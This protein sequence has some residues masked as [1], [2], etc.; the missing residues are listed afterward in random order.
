MLALVILIQNYPAYEC[1]VV[2]GMCH[3]LYTYLSSNKH[4][5]SMSVLC[6]VFVFIDVG[7]ITRQGY[8]KKRSRLLSPYITQ[9]P[10]THTH[11]HTHTHTE[12]D[13]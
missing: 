9:P 2:C 4:P 6:I 10:G 8:E 7:D 12:S 1:I 5:V 3:I 13:L 11:T